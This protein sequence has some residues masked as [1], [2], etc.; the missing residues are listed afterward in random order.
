[1]SFRKGKLR[2]EGKK[3]I[4]SERGLLQRMEREFMQRIMGK[5]LLRFG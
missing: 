3:C 5:G 1:M 2:K 4:Y